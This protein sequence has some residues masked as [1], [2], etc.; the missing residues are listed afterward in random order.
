MATMWPAHLRR[1]VRA[2]PMRRAEVEVYHGLAAALPAAWTVWYSR[3]WLGLTSTGAER[4]GEADFVIAHPERGVLMLEVKGG[5][6]SMEPSTGDWTSR[7]RLGIVHAIKNPIAQARSSKYEILKKLKAMRGWQE[8]RLR[9]RHGVVFPDAAVPDRALGADAPREIFCDAAEF[10]SDLRGWIE[11]RLGRPDAAVREV[12]LGQ[13]GVDQ[14]NRLLATPIM[15]HMP[16]SVLI[17]DD[18][19]TFRELTVQQYHLIELLGEVRRAAIAG[20]A[21]TGKTILA[22]EKAR[23]GAASGRRTLVTC[24]NRPLADQLG[25]ILEGT[26]VDVFTFHAFCGHAARSAG[27]SVPANVSQNEL[28]N[29]VL[30]E[31]LVDATSGGDWRSY[32]TIIV[33][34]GQDFMGHWWVALESAL[35]GRADGEFYVFHDDN[36]ALYGDARALPTSAVLSPYRLSRNLRNTRR[37]FAGAAVHYSGGACEAIGPEGRSIEWLPC[38]SQAARLER[39]ASVIGRMCS[40]E[41][42]LPEEIGLLTLTEDEAASFRGAIRQGAG[43]V[44]LGEYLDGAITVDTIRRFKGLE[45]S[46]IVLSV[47]DGIVEEPELA[48]VAMSR[49]RSH[50]VVLGTS[51][52]IPFL[53]GAKRASRST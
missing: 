31:L 1:E 53:Q 26:G 19:R 21:G 43:C 27:L 51:R 8:R 10:R 40:V 32:D 11:R 39:V 9:L 12:A 4:D 46:I 35:G 41:K 44:R 49:P 2:D 47:D 30:P 15:L 17:E 48:Y 6:I 20:A 23:R 28:S 22:L 45:R 29:V 50:L 13:G 3:P 37:I 24:F 5:A 52:A 18:E 36:Q 42:L 34:E 16:M 33:D 14:L 7:D 25:R 38:E